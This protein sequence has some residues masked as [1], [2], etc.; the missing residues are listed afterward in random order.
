MMQ[1]FDIITHIHTSSSAY[2]QQVLLLSSSLYSSL[3]LAHCRN[4]HSITGHGTTH[5][6][7]TAAHVPISSSPVDTYLYLLV[8]YTYSPSSS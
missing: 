3:L 8:T 6:F 7:E 5:I 4:M 2:I 1:Q